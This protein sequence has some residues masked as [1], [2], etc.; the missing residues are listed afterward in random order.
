M[1]PIKDMLSGETGVSVKRSVLVW[2]VLLFTFTCI[3]NLVTGHV[4]LPE[5]RD[6]LFE[7]IIISLAT[8]FGEPAIKGLATKYRRNNVNE[9]T[10]I[11][12]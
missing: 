7:L 5:L 11:I 6:Q 2:F 10:G 4:L 8:V 9:Q 1:N 3:Y 12:K